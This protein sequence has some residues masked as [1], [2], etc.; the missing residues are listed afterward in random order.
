MQDKLKSR[1]ETEGFKE[2]QEPSVDHR[3]R[4]MDRLENEMPQKRKGLQFNISYKFMRIAAVVVLLISAISFSWFWD[5]TN[6]SNQ[7]PQTLTLAAISEKYEEV[8]L[9]YQDQMNS[10][11]NELEKEDVDAEKNVYN[12]AVVKLNKLSVDYSKLESDLAKNPGNTRIVFAMIKNYQLRITVLETL[13]QK[14]N[15]QETQ[16]SEENEKADLYTIFPVGFHL[17]PVAA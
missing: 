13:L 8:E 5:H 12:E 11:L 9:F 6:V 16:K 2:E 7:E 17:I 1:F 10:R 15:I 14:L 4:F 3:S